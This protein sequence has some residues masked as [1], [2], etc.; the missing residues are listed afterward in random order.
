MLEQGQS[1]H[2]EE[3]GAAEI[4]CDKLNS[5]YS[6]LPISL[7]TAV[8]MRMRNLEVKNRK[9][10]EEGGKLFLKFDFL[11]DYPTLLDQ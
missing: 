11:S 7:S 1:P 5:P 9:K 10:E 6:P 2:P 4:T 3:E 8:G